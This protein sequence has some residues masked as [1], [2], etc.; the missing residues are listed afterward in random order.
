M[1]ILDPPLERRLARIEADLDSLKEDMAIIKTKLENLPSRWM[2][3]VFAMAILIPIYGI[4]V[5]L[6]IQ[7]SK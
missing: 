5:S 1:T 4:L 2:Q 3:Y 7:V 6:L